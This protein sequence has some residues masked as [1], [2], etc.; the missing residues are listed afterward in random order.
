M[1]V[2]T[3]NKSTLVVIRRLLGETAAKAGT[4]LRLKDELALKTGT[5]QGITYLPASFLNHPG[6]VFKNE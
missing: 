6:R 5:C 1:K 4:V 3:R 2:E